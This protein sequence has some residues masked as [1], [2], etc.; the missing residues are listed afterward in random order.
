MNN[1]I[2][3]DLQKLFPKYEIHMIW[4]VDEAKVENIVRGLV[5]A[6]GEDWNYPIISWNEKKYEIL[7]EK[8]MH[9]TENFEKFKN[10]LDNII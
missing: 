5:R 6:R 1:K 3:I 9:L 4:F 7:T 8:N 2:I 10:V